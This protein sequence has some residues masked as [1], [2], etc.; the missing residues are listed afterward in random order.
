MPRYNFRKAAKSKDDLQQILS[1]ST[2]LTAT[3]S[4]ANN[5][6]KNRLAEIYPQV[7]SEVDYDWHRFTLE[8]LVGEGRA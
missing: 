5:N 4:R 3:V 8:F 2:W 7:A 6:K 1:M